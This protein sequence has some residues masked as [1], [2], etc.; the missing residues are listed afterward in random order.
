MR[1]RLSP[2]IHRLDY[3]R[4]W[5]HKLNPTNYSKQLRIL[6]I[7]FLLSKSTVFELNSFHKKIVFFKNYNFTFY[8]LASSNIY[9]YNMKKKKRF[10]DLNKRSKAKQKRFKI[11]KTL[12]KEI[13]SFFILRKIYFFVFLRKL[14]NCNI[15]IKEKNLFRLVLKS[16]TYLS[17]VKLI[18]KKPSM[19]KFSRLRHMNNTFNICTLVTLFETSRLI[20]SHIVKELKNNKNQRSLFYSIRDVFTQFLEDKILLNRINGFTL[21]VKGKIQKRRRKSKLILQS[22]A[23]EVQNLDI[24]IDYSLKYAITKPGVLSIRIWLNGTKIIK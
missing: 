4:L 6:F 23:A 1:G 12:K 2:I 8:I 11:L 16:A 20:S 21:G 17:D 5:D 13:N 22:G 10:D 9:L 19:K 7:T 24:R 15:K 3:S 14:K 18:Q